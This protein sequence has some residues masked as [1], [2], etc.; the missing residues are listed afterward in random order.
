MQLINEMLDNTT[1]AYPSKEAIILENSTLTYRELNQNVNK[2]ANGLKKLGIGKGDLVMVQLVNGPEIIISH[3][4]IIKAGATVVP[5]N[6]MYVAHEILYI[7]EDTEAK[8]IIVDS[9]F[10]PVLEEVR[11]G[12]PELEYIIVVG[13]TVPESAVRFQDLISSCSDK[14]DPYDA[15]F[16]DIVSI[17]Y[18]SGTTGR[19]KGAT[20]THRS[21]LANASSCCDFNKFCNEDRLLCALPLFN[22]FAINVVMMSSFFSGATIIVVDRFEAEKV[23]ENITNHKTTYFAG[24]PTMFVYLIQAFD[25]GTHD[26]SQMRV[27]NSGGAHCPAKVIEDVEKAFG[28]TFMDGY[29]QTEGCGFTTLNPIVGVRKP[30]SVGVPI[31]NIWVKIVDDNFVELPPNEVGEIVEKGDVFSIHGYWKRPEI[32]EEAYREGWFHSGDLGYVDEDGYLYVVDRKQDLIITGGA[33]IYPVEVEET[34]YTHPAVALAAV[35]GIPDEVKGEL[36][37]AYIVLKEGTTATEK[38]IIDYVRGGIAKYK[39]PRMV[40]F[41]ETLPQGPTG[42][43]L[44]RELREEVFKKN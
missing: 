36:A 20:Q 5:L 9:R 26:V 17:I 3:Y 39:A 8:A 38:E 33:N 14:H 19:P 32:N 7:G 44:K 28:V 25:P 34:L 1:K 31:A 23:L 4:A 22:N 18:T 41:M 12:L 21:I 43:I 13:D 35:I 27:V 6:V 37:K 42:K 30:D 24:T 2:L 11:P 29:G 15:D 16:D 40:E 10:L